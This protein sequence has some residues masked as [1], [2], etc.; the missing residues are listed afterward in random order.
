[1]TTGLLDN[2]PLLTLIGVIAAAAIAAIPAWLKNKAEKKTTAFSQVMELLRQVRDENK[3]LR[4]RVEALEEDR[5]TDRKKIRHMEDRERER[6]ELRLDYLTHTLAVEDWESE[7]GAASGVI[8]PRPSYKVLQDIE[9]Y[10][11]Q[12]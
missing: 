3:D 10:K 9:E 6:E 1:M 5:E 11:K 8:R 12:R 7:G 2:P 4:E